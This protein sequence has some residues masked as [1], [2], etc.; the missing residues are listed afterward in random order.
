[1]G[2]YLQLENIRMSLWVPECQSAQMQPMNDHLVNS[3]QHLKSV[4]NHKFIVYVAPD[5]SEYS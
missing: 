2:S 3:L 4:V 1:M 5:W